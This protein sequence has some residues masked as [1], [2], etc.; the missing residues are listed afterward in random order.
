MGNRGFN[1]GGFAYMPIVQCTEC[2]ARFR[3]G[4]KNPRRYCLNKIK[5]KIRRQKRELETQTKV[6]A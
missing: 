4:N 2:G 5:C 3:I 6:E 1:A